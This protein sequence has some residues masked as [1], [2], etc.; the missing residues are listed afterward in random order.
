MHVADRPVGVVRQR[1][2]RLHRHQ[3]ALECRHA[4]E[5]DRHHHHAQHRI[6]AQ[7]VPRARERHQAV[8]H[9]APRRHPQHDRE[10]HA[11]RLR[12]VRQR[13]VVQVVRAGP[14]VEEDQRPEV[15]DRK[16][17]GIDRPLGPLRDEVIHDREEAGG[18]EE[19]D[20]VVAVPPL[21]HR[22][23]HA[24]PDDVGLRREQRHRDRGV[25]AEMQHRNRQD[26]G[27]IEPVGDVDVR[28]A[29]PHDGAEKDQEVDDPDDREPEVGIPLRLGVFLRLGDAEQIAGAGDDNEEIVAEHD[30]PG[31]DVAGEAGAAGALHDIERG[32]DQHVAAE[33]ED[34]RRC[35]QR[36]DAAERKPRQIEIEDRKG[37]LERRPQSDRKAGNAPDHRGDGREL[38]RAHVVVGL[39]VDG[40]RR[41]LGRTVVVAVDDRERGGDACG[42]KQIGVKRVFGRI[43]IRRDE[44][45]EERQRHERERRSALADGHGLWCDGRKSHV[46]YPR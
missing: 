32:R 33:G 1:V 6:G 13:G 26:E 36:A 27:E 17:I 24:R 21:H 41:Q 18:E 3:R 20:R 29:A 37:E 12:P 30:E 16:P 2:H 40:E 25:V 46:Y 44:E 4:V 31:R 39:A 11:E 38:D 43:G 35:M 15:D 5:G 9:A 22:V 7:L 19:A 28:L 45:R 34:H 42:G 8:D 23:L 10:R 14:D